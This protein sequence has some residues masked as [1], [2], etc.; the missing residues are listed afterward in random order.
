MGLLEDLAATGPKPEPPADF[1]PRYDLDSQRGGYVVSTPFT[2]DTEP[3][4]AKVLEDFD[5]DPQKWVITSYRTARW[6]T[7]DERWLHSLRLNVEPATAV[8]RARVDAEELIA[9]VAKWR[10]RKPKQVDT[11]TYLHIPVG[12]T[13]IGKIDGGGSE[14]TVTRFLNE[15]E[16]VAH[17]QRTIKAHHIH[18]PWL[19]D[20][21]EGNVSQGGKVA[22]RTDLTVTEQVR[23]IRRLTLAQ[24]KALAPLTDHITIAAVPGNHDETSRQLH[25]TG[26][27][28]WA[29]DALSAVYDAVQENEELKHR[30]SFVFPN[31]DDLTITQDFG[32]I[33]IALAHGH[34][35]KPA[36]DA[37]ALKWWDGQASGRTPAGSADLLLSAHRHHLAIRDHGGGRLWLQIPALDGGSAWFTHRYGADSP[38]RLLSFTTEGKRIGNLDP[39]L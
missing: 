29:V 28:S 3:D 24:I 34:Q 21:I 16:R 26:D 19:G 17:R 23:I 36:T 6:Q 15:L 32:D 20:C 39:V 8:K 11:D 37:G 25:T 5:L 18:L 7:Y 33:R 9:R 31:T 2:P 38:P 14:A 1:K 10:P 30:V 13:Q 27:D 35:F 22:G 12:D 4:H